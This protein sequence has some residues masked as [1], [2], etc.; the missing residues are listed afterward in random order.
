M[1]R[2]IVRVAMNDPAS[3][4]E[5]AGFTNADVLCWAVSVMTDVMIESGVKAAY[6]YVRIAEYRNPRIY[7]SISGSVHSAN[8]L[9]EVTYES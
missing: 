9:K 3:W 2:L 8:V 5:L 1:A 7:G 4:N 6:M